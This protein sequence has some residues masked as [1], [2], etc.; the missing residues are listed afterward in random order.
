MKKYAII[1]ACL[2]LSLGTSFG[3][4]GGGG[5][6][7]TGAGTGSAIG[8]S[9]AGAVRAPGT[10]RLPGTLTPNNRRPL[11]PAIPGANQ[12]TLAPGAVDTT[13]GAVN[14]GSLPIG[15]VPATGAVGTSGNTVGVGTGTGTDTGA[16]GGVGPGIGGTGGTGVGTGATGSFGPNATGPTGTTAD[17]ATGVTGNR[18]AGN[19]G[20]LGTPG[21]LG[22]MAPADMA[23]A[24]QIRAQLL[25]GQTPGAV[26]NGAVNAGNAI[27]PQ[28]LAGVQISANNGVVT[29]RGRVNSEAERRVLETRIRTITGVRTIVNGLTVAGPNATT[30]ATGT[31]TPGGAVVPGP[32]P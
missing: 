12:G 29:L 16:I 18:G 9:A 32:T 31:T 21:T 1:L 11:N 14:S 24:Q 4:T 19:A 13:Q 22:A 30:G 17:V 10:Q 15:T 5:G 3:Q 26:G 23:L 28:G 8:G 6:G 25:M 2:A 27:P 7:A 20:P